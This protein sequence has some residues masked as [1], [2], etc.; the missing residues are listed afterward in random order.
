M[1]RKDDIRLFEVEKKTTNGIKVNVAKKSTRLLNDLE[2]LR[3][4]QGEFYVES[5]MNRGRIKLL[6]ILSVK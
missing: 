4:K 1:I 3:V 6:S 2:V 5:K